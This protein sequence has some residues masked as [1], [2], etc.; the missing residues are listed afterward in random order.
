MF[1][2]LFNT[3]RDWIK[4]KWQEFEGWIA[5][6]LPRWKTR[7]TLILGFIGNAAYAAQGYLPGLSGV[8][9]PEMMFFAN[10]TL[11]ALAYFFRD[12]SN[13]QNV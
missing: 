6:F 4:E 7:I 11:F 13:R 10:M 1:K 12:L 2:F 3:I 9:T 5:T 8:I